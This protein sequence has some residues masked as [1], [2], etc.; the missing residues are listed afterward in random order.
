VGIAAT[1]LGSAADAE[2]LLAPLRAAAPVEMDLM[3]EVPVGRLG[4]VAAE[5]TDPMPGME[6]S[7]LLHGLD[8][9][10]ID[11]LVAVVADPRTSPLAVVQIRGL[12]GAFGAISSAHG[13]VTPV[14]AAFQLFA[15]GVPAVPEL[16]AAIPHAF[17]AIDAAVGH[18]AT[19]RRMP[20]F[21]GDGQDDTAG[22]D[23]ATMVRLQ[24]I[25]R[26]RDPLGVIRS[27]KPVLGV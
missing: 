10:T 11:K 15:L 12:G 21:S 7:M 17:A 22:Y 6:H 1:H 9:C 20:N 23:P 3:G 2:R 13:A 5:P 4:E 14:A 16:A 27:N 26:S 25:K 24:E 8:N 18:Y 19:G